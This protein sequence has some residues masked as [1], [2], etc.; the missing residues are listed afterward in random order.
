MSTT[1]KSTPS[2]DASGARN[3]PRPR[4]VAKNDTQHGKCRKTPRAERATAPRVCKGNRPAE[5]THQGKIAP[6]E[7]ANLKAA[8]NFVRD[9]YPEAIFEFH[10]DEGLCSISECPR[11]PEIS[12]RCLHPWRAWI[13]AAN[14]IRKRLRRRAA[15]KV[16]A[17]TITKPKEPV[18][19]PMR[20]CRRPKKAAAK[21][22]SRSKGKSRRAAGKP[23]RMLAKHSETPGADDNNSRPRGVHRAMT[24]PSIIRKFLAEKAKRTDFWPYCYPPW[25]R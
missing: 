24:P 4:S 2:T 21:D 8:V 23:V 20:R 7:K 25:D 14:R 10:K 5:T 17:H 6:F 18:K 12:R 13:N 3:R 16:A 9:F 22:A 19:R 11:G 15:A 1:F